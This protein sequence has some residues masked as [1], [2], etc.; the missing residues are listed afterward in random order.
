[1]ESKH[2]EKER[3][4]RGGGGRRWEEGELLPY[5]CPPQ[6]IFIFVIIHVGYI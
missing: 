3:R 5:F 2:C 1:M 4:G 6:Y